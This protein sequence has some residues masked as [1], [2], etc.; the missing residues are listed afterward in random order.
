MHLYDL[1]R[2]KFVEAVSN[3]GVYSSEFVNI[4]GIQLHESLYI[5]EKYNDGCSLSG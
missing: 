1:H 2:Q 5:I 4:R 3:N